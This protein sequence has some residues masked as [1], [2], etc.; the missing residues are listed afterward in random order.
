[1]PAVLMKAIADVLQ[2]PSEGAGVFNTV[3]LRDLLL[4]R[5][6]HPLSMKYYDMELKACRGWVGQPSVLR[7]V[8]EALKSLGFPHPGLLELRVYHFSGIRKQSP[9]QAS[10]SK[11]WVRLWPS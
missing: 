7:V 10:S 8:V 3:A 9:R 1:M 2:Q 11:A 6:A 4:P 5:I